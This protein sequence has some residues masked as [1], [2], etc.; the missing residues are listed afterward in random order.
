M[1]KYDI[2][3][4]NKINKEKPFTFYVEFSTKEETKAQLDLSS[5]QEGISVELRWHDVV[6]HLK[7][8]KTMKYCEKMN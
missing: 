7:N 4:F 3:P 6:C 5:D 8:M 1:K 2:C